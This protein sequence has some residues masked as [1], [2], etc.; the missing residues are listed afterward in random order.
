MKVGVSRP[1]CFL[2]LVMG[3]LLFR[4]EDVEIERFFD[5]KVSLGHIVY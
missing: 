2:T 5:C 1:L 4:A 3:L